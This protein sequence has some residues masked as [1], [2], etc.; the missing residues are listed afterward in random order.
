MPHVD[1]AENKACFQ[2][3]HSRGP[4]PPVDSQDISMRIEAE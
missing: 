3:Q 2:S 1:S 4:A